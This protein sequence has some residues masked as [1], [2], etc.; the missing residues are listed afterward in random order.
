MAQ[1]ALIDGF[2]AFWA[3]LSLW[4]LWENLRRPNDWRWLVAYTVSLAAM[5]L[6]KENAAFAYFGLLVLLAVNRW[7]KFGTITNK[8]LLLTIAGPLAGKFSCSSA[9]VAVLK[10]FSTPI[11]CS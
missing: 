6:T 10:R 8:L 2:F 1:H 7:A 4:F 3:T 9:S 5:V 11:G